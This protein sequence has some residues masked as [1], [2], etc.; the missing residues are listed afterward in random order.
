[1]E[2]ITDKAADE[3][4]AELDAARQR[5]A[6]RNARSAARLAAARKSQKRPLLSR[7]FGSK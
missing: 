3:F 7:I 4:R 1:M 2:N 5:A 6:E